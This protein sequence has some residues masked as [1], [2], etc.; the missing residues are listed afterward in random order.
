MGRAEKSVQENTMLLLQGATLCLLMLPIHERSC[1]VCCEVGILSTSQTYQKRILR[2]FEHR[3][4]V[5]IMVTG[6]YHLVCIPTRCLNAILLPFSARTSK[7][8][9]EKND[10][11][12]LTLG[13]R[14]PSLVAFG[15]SLKKIVKWAPRCRASEGT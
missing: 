1:L 6:N 15:E 9:P 10:S 3:L 2:Q 11:F 14:L 12:F 4:V 7:G 8:G 5:F 13:Q